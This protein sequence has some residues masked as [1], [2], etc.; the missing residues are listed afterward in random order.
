MSGYGALFRWGTMYL[1][2]SLISFDTCAYRGS[3]GAHKSLLP[4]LNK[5]RNPVKSMMK[6]SANGIPLTEVVK[7]IMIEM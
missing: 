4:I 5:K 2:V 6:T 7:F 1:P 3:S